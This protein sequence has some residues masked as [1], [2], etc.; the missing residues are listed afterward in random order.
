MRLAN[1]NVNMQIQ[2]EK[3]MIKGIINYFLEKKYNSKRKCFTYLSEKRE[4]VDLV[5][6]NKIKNVIDNSLGVNNDREVASKYFVRSKG[7]NVLERNKE[8]LPVFNVY[9]R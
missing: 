2:G 5:E 3:I 9:T 8:R 7:L 1:I 6:R 4:I